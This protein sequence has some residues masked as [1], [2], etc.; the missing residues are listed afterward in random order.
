MYH[1]IGNVGFIGLGRMGKPMAVNIV[2]A[3]FSL[4]VY[5]SREDVVR[6]LTQFGA[7]AAG[8]RKR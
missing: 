2:N 1:R 8:S 3:G 7:N 5:D 6:E 4:T